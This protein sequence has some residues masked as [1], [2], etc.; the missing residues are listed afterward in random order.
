[1]TAD[2]ATVPQANRVA[3]T[4]TT[5]NE[6][7]VVSDARTTKPAAATSRPTTI[8]GGRPNRTDPVAAAGAAAPMNTEGSRL[9]NAALS[10]E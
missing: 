2:T 7:T 5:A 4:S 9:H 8:V 10:G 1:M 3:P 6:W